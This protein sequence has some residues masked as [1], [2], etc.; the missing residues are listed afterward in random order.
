MGNKVRTCGDKHLTL[1]LWIVGLVITV[2]LAT[3]AYANSTL[4][5]VEGR[6]RS[7]EQSESANAARFEA[8]QRSLER[9]E[10]VAEKGRQ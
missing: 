5:A 7:V 9:L 4:A 2:C 10:R 3:I 1:A 6:V 8:I